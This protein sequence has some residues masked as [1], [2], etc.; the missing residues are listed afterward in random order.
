MPGH[1]TPDTLC[2]LDRFRLQ[3]YPGTQPGAATNSPDANHESNPVE[4]Q[5]FRLPVGIFAAFGLAARGVAI[6]AGLA[7]AFALWAGLMGTARAGA[8]TDDFGTSVNY[9]TAG[10]SGTLWDGILYQSAANVLNTSGTA[11]QLTIGTPSSAV[12]WDGTHANAPLLYK[13]VTGDFDARVQVTAGTT[14]NYTIA[15]LLVR[16]DPASADG[17]A[18]EDFV[19]LTR[20]WGSGIAGNQL[21]RVNDNA[22]SDSGILTPAQAYL[23][24]TRTGNVFRGY[25]SSD[26][27]T[28]TQ[29]AWGGGGLDLTRT[30]LAGTVQLGLTE[31]AFVAGNVTWVRF[32]NF[33]LITP[34]PPLTWANGADGNWPIGTWSGGPPAYP[35]SGTP[36]II[37][38]PWTVTVDSSQAALSLGVSNGGKVSVTATGGLTVSGTTTLAGG[39]LEIAS[40][41][42]FSLPT[43][44]LAGGTLAVS[45]TRTI[46]SSAIT[47]GTASTFGTPAET[48]SITLVSPLG[49]SGG[50]TKTGAGTLILAGANTCTGDTTVEAGGLVFTAPAS[51]NCLSFVVK[52]SSNNKITG[53]GSATLNGPFHIDL[54]DSSLAGLAS[55]T[56]PL[57]DVATKTYGTSFKIT[58]A[59]GGWTLSSGVWTTTAG[60]KTWSLTQSTGVLSG[61]ADFASWATIQGLT[62]TPG[63]GS[64]V[65]PAFTAD[66]NQDGIENGLAWI[67]GAD[68]LGNPAANRLKLPAVSRD[69][70][71]ALVLTFDRLTASAADAPLVVQYSDNLGATPWTDFTVNTSA[72]T[73]TDG[74]ISIAVAPGGG[75]S[76]VYDRIT[77]TFPATYLAAHPKSF[78]RLM[79]TSTVT[80]PLPPIDSALLAQWSAPYRNWHYQPNHVI[81]SAPNI[82]GYASFQGTDVPTVFQLPGDTTK[83]YMTFIAFDGGGYQSFIAESTDLV[84]WT[85]RRLAMPFGPAGAFDYGGVVLGAYLYESYDIKARR[86]LKLKDGKFWSLYGAYD[87]RTGYEAG[88]GSNGLASSSDG[89]NWTRFQNQP[90]LSIHDA[91]RGAW[92]NSVI[93]QPWLV[94]HQGMFY[95][96]Y[97]AKGG[98]EQTGTAT[99]SDLLS[100]TRYANNPVIPV[101]ASI[102]NSS[103][104]SDPKV[105]RDGNHW[106]CFFFGLGAGGAH[107]MAAFSWDLYNWTVDPVPLY[108]AGGNPSGLDSSYAHKISLVWNPANETF[109]MY[110]NAVGNKGR[111][112][113]LITSKQL[114]PGG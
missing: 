18:G 57:V 52:A 65:D 53:T 17:N 89:V 87:S 16:L 100:W 4:L 98:P 94:E 43:V 42:N 80:T 39:T 37:D 90:V 7:V 10:V 97:N 73:T 23:R 22:Q 54:S 109:Y 38:T 45:G 78:A 85:N 104:S 88:V 48:D 28:W 107:I 113:G 9:L 49:G 32:D 55:H 67:L 36:A 91:D 56:W 92:E 29:R 103:F 44:N 14:P 60:S 58:G 102:Y 76:A 74:N 6:R 31:G 101:G 110:Y 62:G 5:S 27:I 93:Y 71:G 95:N 106:V 70:T 61:T 82:P 51:G 77:V 69:G 75:S 96:F 20:N 86:T 79:A 33:T 112:I 47:L 3:D 50:L 64:N 2:L 46:S 83:W 1:R 108:L 40:G 13:N 24:L 11:G 68:A 81:S 111:G 66:P 21:R 8:V 15:G 26:G 105:F 114:T 12:G 30:D 63:D 72:G 34:D 25:F 84:N 41:A 59:G 35:D 99:S 19:M